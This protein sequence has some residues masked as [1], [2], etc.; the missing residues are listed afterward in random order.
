MKRSLLLLGILLALACAQ[1]SADE[2][3]Y[4]YIN[5]PIVKVY[6]HA[7]GY[8]VIYKVGSTRT[9]SAYLPMSW[10]DYPNSPNKVDYGW[11]PTF[12]Y[13][14]VFYKEGKMS[15]VRL[16]LNWDINDSRWGIFDQTVDGKALF[17]G[18]KELKLQF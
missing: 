12:P 8:Q 9:A 17:E 18:V 6:S 16:H 13:M 11:G 10:F 7:M 1:A 14:T 2:S 3:E 4:Y 5:V 15:H